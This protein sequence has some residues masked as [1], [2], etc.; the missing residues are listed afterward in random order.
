MPPHLKLLEKKLFE[1]VRGKCKRLI[2]SMPPRHGKSQMISRYFPFWYLGRHPDKRIIL[3]SYSHDFAASWGNKLLAH[4]REHGEAMFDTR[5]NPKLQ[6]GDEFEFLGHDGGFKAVGIGG[7]GMGRGADILIIDDPIKNPEEALSQT[8][9]EKHWDWYTTAAESRLEPGGTVILVMTRWHYDDLAGRIIAYSKEHGEHW[10]I[11]DLP[12]LAETN[13]I[14][15]REEGEALWPARYDRADLEQKRRLN[16]S[17]WFSALYQQKPIAGEYQIFKEEYWRFYSG[18]PKENIIF[19]VTF[20][21]TAFKSGEMNDYSVGL[22]MA[23]TDR[24]FYVVGMYRGKPTFEQ[25]K[26]A[27]LQQY[28][29]FKPD[30]I[31]IEDAASGQSLLQE[32]KFSREKLP[33][34]AVAPENKE[35]KAHRVS[36]QFENNRVYLREGAQYNGDIITEL[37]AFPSGAHDDIVDCFTGCIEYLSRMLKR[38]PGTG[39]VAAKPSGIKNINMY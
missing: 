25:L 28:Q 27:V 10:D 4:F 33:I 1:V 24:H 38:M 31:L 32:L 21:D 34:K 9:R 3:A 26:Q 37:A 2:V 17:F 6:R 14:L 18:L 7:G 20:W 12:A 19:T 5:L 29:A 16:G 8:I 11:I 35:I 22:T 39:F 15:G 23:V 30:K 13:D 36:A